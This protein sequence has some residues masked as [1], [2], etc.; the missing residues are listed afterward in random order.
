MCKDFYFSVYESVYV[1]NFQVFK[2][3]V[4]I[5]GITFIVL[6]TAFWW[7]VI[8]AMLWFDIREKNVLPIVREQVPTEMPITVGSVLVQV[9]VWHS[10]VCH[11]FENR[12]LL[13]WTRL[14]KASNLWGHW[15]FAISLKV[16][17]IVLQVVENFVVMAGSVVVIV[18]TDSVSEFEPH[19][20][21]SLHEVLLQTI[22]SALRT[23][24]TWYRRSFSILPIRH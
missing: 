18:L 14:L 11:T 10:Q 24:R 6:I 17:R 19:L 8:V 2:I 22:V 16:T 3:P 20:L 9:K 13:A 21:I 1:F 15:F 4:F 7:A 5:D 12:C 23:I